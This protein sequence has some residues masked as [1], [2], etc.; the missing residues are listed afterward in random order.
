L[1]NKCITL[2][3]ISRIWLWSNCRRILRPYESAQ[4]KNG[5]QGN[6]SLV[7]QT[8][9]DWCLPHPFQCTEITNLHINGDKQC[10]LKAY[11]N[12]NFFDKGRAYRKYIYNKQSD[13]SIE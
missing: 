12:V 8:I 13:W 3:V 2:N 9:V 4:K 5:G 1:E 11:R 6:S 7:Q 10:N